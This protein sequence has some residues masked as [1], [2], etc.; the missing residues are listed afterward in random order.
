MV[1]SLFKS[2]HVRDAFS[3]AGSLLVP[4]L[5]AVAQ[6]PCEGDEAVVERVREEWCNYL[7]HRSL[8]E[9]VRG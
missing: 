7:T 9:G 4:A 5:G 8:S 3:L 6:V 2:G 1:S